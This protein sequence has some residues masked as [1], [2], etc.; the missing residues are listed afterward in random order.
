MATVQRKQCD[1]FGS[2]NNIE[3]FRVMV[4]KVD[5]HDIAGPDPLRVVTKD[6]CPRALGRLDNFIVRGMRPPSEKDTVEPET[7]IEEDAT[8][9]GTQG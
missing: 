7:P 5:E 9:A 4:F 3:R 8:V 6:L 2:F 1:V